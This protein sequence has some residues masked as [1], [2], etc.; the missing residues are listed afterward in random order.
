MP[1]VSKRV[2]ALLTTLVLTLGVAAAVSSTPA[3]AAPQ[4][5]A[6]LDQK[7]GK[8]Q[9]RTA[10]ATKA[11]KKAA[12]KVKR[13]KRA[14]AK[15]DTSANKKKLTKAKKANRKAAKKVR[16]W[17]T[18]NADARRAAARC[19]AANDTQSPPPSPQQE[20]L[21]QLLDALAGAGLDPAQVQAIAEQIAG[22]LAGGDVSPETL[23]TVLE[24]VVDALAE[25]GLPA[26]QIS[27]AV[28]QVLGALSGGDLP[29]DPSGL[30][31]LV[32]D[33]LQEALTG[34]PLDQ[35]NDI[36]EQVQTGL[37]SLLGGLLGGGGLPL[38]IP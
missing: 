4:S 30:I 20:Q 8:T 26:D 38:P 9:V 5:C 21:Q 7:Y 37:G 6:K 22:A 27:D 13:A 1:H 31:D 14:Y 2:L 12:K 34:T 23:L 35:L 33:S 11:K 36:L 25:A 24:P 29:S 16:G 10:Q 17:R 32:V 28:Q 3:A 19:H 18:R 15:K